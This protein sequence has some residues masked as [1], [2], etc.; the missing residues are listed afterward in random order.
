MDARG[1]ALSL[2]ITPVTGLPEVREGDDLVALIGDAL[3]AAGLVPAAGDVLVVASKVVSKAEGQRLVSDIEPD[4]EARRVAAR[5]GQPLAEVAAVLAETATVLRAEPGVL[6]VETKHGYV[7]ANAGVDRSNTGMP[8]TALLLPADP[9]AGAAR[10]QAGLVARYGTP[11]AVLVS[12]TFGRPFRYGLV[13]IA[14]GVA[15]MRPIRDYR[16]QK[17]P[18]G[19]PLSGTEL[20]VADELCAAAELVM[21]KL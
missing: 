4:A 20:A 6:V 16:G 1:P 2:T 12:D 7:C 8:G 5:T 9:D 13:N 14:L 15:G 17:D 21:N 11:L 3:D 10:I 18:E 19:R